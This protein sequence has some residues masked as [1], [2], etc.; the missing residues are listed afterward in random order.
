MEPGRRINFSHALTP[1]LAGRDAVRRRDG[2]TGSRP[3]LPGVPVGFLASQL[4]D[5]G[6]EL[7][8]GFLDLFGRPP[9]E[10]A[11]ECERSTG[12]MLGP[13]VEPGQWPHDCRGDRR[14]AESHYVARGRAARTTRSWSKNCSWRFWTAFRSPRNRPPAS[15]AI[16]GR[17][18]RIRQCYRR[19]YRRV[20]A[21]AIAGAASRLGKESNRPSPG[22][23]STIA[24]HIDRR[25]RRS[26]TGRRAI[27]RDGHESRRGSIHVLAH[28]A[29]GRHHGGAHRS[30]ADASLPRRRSRTHGRTA[31]SCS[32]EF[33]LSA[34]PVGSGGGQEPSH[35]RRRGRFSQE[36]YPAVNAIDGDAKSGWAVMRNIG[37]PHMGIF[38][39]DGPITSRRQQ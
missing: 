34:A 38:E 1:A 12:V 28:D 19:S 3:R 11:C 35:A 10:S 23:R 26:R 24:R 32:A 27:C 6:V 22:R 16:N 21:R 39:T 36:G 30:A 17:E 18:R 31:T 8:D 5:S 14:S 15:A 29:A 37:K 33:A 13:G 7:A 2:R 9:R 20:R 4:P 25:G